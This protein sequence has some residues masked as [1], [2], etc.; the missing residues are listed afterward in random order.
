MIPETTSRR[1]L[2]AIQEEAEHAT[3]QFGSF[4]SA[5][6]A[7]AVMWEEVEEFWEWVRCK[8]AERDPKKMAR[9]LVQIAAC[10]VKAIESLKLVEHL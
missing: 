1:I 8:R 3:K 2:Q 5:H 10:A 9:E 4:N 6:E 7:Y